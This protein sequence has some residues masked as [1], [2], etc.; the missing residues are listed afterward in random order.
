LGANPVRHHLLFAIGTLHEV[1]Q[2]DCIV[3]AA[4]ITPAFAQFTFW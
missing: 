4:A 2:A 3:C 1:R